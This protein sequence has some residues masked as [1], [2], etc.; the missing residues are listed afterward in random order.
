MTKSQEIE[1]LRELAN[2]LGSNSYVGPWI[3][4]E[5]PSIEA[6]I[7]ADYPPQI[8]WRQARENADSVVNEAKAQAAE[9]LETAQK[10]AD[11]LSDD[12][13][14]FR[15]SIISHAHAE[16]NRCLKALENY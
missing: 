2:R 15:A 16:L 14:K 12:S 7:R 4:Q 11:R 8:T 1:A 5:I 10:R 6:D 9:I 13:K 3:L